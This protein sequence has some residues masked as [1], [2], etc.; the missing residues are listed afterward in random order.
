[1]SL[2]SLPQAHRM[3]STLNLRHKHTLQER[4]FKWQRDEWDGIRRNS[5]G[6]YPGSRGM[7][8]RGETRLS[9]DYG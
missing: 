2:G 5:A 4:S 6:S 9:V 8:R 3:D 7:R 1:M